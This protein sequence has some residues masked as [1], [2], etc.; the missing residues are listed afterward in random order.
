MANLHV[1]DEVEPLGESD[2]VKKEMVSQS[3]RVD[4]LFFRTRYSL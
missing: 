1:R 3:R 4:F 2:W